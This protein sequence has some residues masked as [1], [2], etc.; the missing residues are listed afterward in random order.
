MVNCAPGPA[1][2]LFAAVLV[3]LALA[4]APAVET[5][6]AGNLLLTA[7]DGAVQLQTPAGVRQVPEYMR[8]F[9]FVI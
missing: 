7:P 8:L 2:C 9:A 3:P 6:D 5:D 4:E 1:L